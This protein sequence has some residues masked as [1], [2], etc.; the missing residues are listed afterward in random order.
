MAEKAESARKVC[1]LRRAGARENKK[2]RGKVRQV[3][4]L[5]AR[6][7]AFKLYSLKT[8]LLDYLYVF[9]VFISVSLTKRASI[10]LHSHRN[11]FAPVLVGI[12]ITP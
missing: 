5:R 9:Y 2:E 8:L 1:A 12:Q 4:T 10:F 7:N 11:V 3:R 6:S